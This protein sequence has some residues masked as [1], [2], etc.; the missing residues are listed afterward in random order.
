MGRRIK[1][2]EIFRSYDLISN[3]V[4]AEV[5]LSSQSTTFISGNSRGQVE[6]LP[7]LPAQI[8]QD[9]STREHSTKLLSSRPLLWGRKKNHAS[10]A[11]PLGLLGC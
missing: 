9:S 4:S 1:V 10:I 8:P 5:G 2:V 6:S 7:F 3:V 11:K